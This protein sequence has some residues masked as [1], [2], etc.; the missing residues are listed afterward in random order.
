VRYRAANVNGWSGWSP[1]G[2]I[3]TATVPDAPSAPTLVSATGST[4]TL[5]IN[6]SVINGGSIIRRYKL[7]KD[8]GSLSSAYTLLAMFDADKIAPA[9]YTLTVSDP[10]FGIVSGDR[11]RFFT[12]ATN[13]IGD[14]EASEEVYFTV[15]SIP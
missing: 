3:L 12:V 4:L 13:D 9:T 14:S 11:Y 1:V 15:S 8:G 5:R 10:T 2:F 7:F 6:P